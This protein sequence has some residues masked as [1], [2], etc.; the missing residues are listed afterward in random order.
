MVV[1][2]PTSGPSVVPHRGAEPMVRPR[3]LVSMDEGGSSHSRPRV[4]THSAEEVQVS[5]QGSRARRNPAT[6]A[7][8]PAGRS[9]PRVVR[10]LRNHWGV[11]LMLGIVVVFLT[12]AVGAALTSATPYRGEALSLAA[13]EAL[14]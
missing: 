5:G 7:R 8:A 10:V 14:T 11:V 4:E 9:V 1:S 12:S 3:R 6:T 13:P 2:S